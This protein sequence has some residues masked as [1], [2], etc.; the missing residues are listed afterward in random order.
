MWSKRV[1]DTDIESVWRAALECREARPGFLEIGT[2]R[3]LEHVGPKFDWELGYRTKEEVM[4][5]MA[6]DPVKAARPMLNGKEASA[7][8]ES[9]GAEVLAAFEEAEAAPWPEDI[10]S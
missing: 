3:Y 1:E 8:E 7:L 9:I 10:R 4:E 2:Y 5:H 6:H